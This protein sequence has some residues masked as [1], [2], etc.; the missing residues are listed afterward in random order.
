MGPR[1]SWVADRGT[2]GRGLDVE[3]PRLVDFEVADPGFVDFY[4]AVVL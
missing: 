1:R 4:Y 3:G 2:R